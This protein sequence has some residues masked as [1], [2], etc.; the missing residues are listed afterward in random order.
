VEKIKVIV[1][2]PARLMRE[3]LL[4]MIS[5][6]LDIE[7]MAET[8]DDNK[9]V[10]L[11]EQ[12]HPDWV[13][14]ALDETGNK[15]SICESLFGLYPHLKIL[16]LASGRNDCIFYWASMSIRSSRV[17]SSEQGILDAL[18]GRRPIS[19]GTFEGYGSKKVN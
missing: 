5:G 11:V 13:V 2:S 19:V 8:Q 10:E 9:I 16:A 4:E 7:V 18:R 15:P 1:A 3:V 17:E 6:Q 14:I 12:L